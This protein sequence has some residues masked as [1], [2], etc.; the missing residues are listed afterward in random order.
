MTT[1]KATQLERKRKC[2]KKETNLTLD[3]KNDA[4]RWFP[5]HWYE[6]IS[7][8]TVESTAL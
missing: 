7:A 4:R 1:K 3:K 6:L 2:S 5:N 8:T